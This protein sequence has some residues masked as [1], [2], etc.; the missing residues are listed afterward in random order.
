MLQKSLTT[1]GRDEGWNAGRTEGW[2]VGQEIKVKEMSIS[3]FQNG[4]D[5]DTIV[6]IAQQPLETVRSWVGLS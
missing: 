3:M 4:I 6:K 5:L 1:T 2:N